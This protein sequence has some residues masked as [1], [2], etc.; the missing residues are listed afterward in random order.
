M[1]KISPKE[2]IVPGAI[3]IYLPTGFEI[4]PTDIICKIIR[5]TD[6]HVYLIRK[7]IFGF[8]DLDPLIVQIGTFYDNYLYLAEDN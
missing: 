3:W 8:K 2:R 6:T 1:L 4:K 5:V 7:T